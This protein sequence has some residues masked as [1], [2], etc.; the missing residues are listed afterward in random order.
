MRGSG[1]RIGVDVGATLA[2]VARQDGGGA[3]VFSWFPTDAIEQLAREVESLR[4]EKIALTGGGAAALEGHLRGF[5]TARVGEFEAWAAGAAQLLEDRPGGAPDRYLLVSLGT[6]TSAMLVDGETVTRAGGTALGGGTLS[7]LAAA[8]VG[9]TRFEAIAELARQGDR[10]R[11]DLQVAE[12]YPGRDAPLPGDL[13]ASSFAKLA[14]NGDEPS[15]ADLVR[16]VVGL[17]GE[18]VALVCGWM[19]AALGVDLIVYGGST[20]RGNAALEE[21]LVG[22][23]A[24]LGRE[25]VILPN[26]EYTG[27]IGALEAA[28]A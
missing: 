12:V 13:N 1:T 8:L 23:G 17:V 14:R 16:G 2:K 25:V 27:A 21:I 4:P 20:L 11:V 6:G 28:G 19:A 18:N 5:D 10:R 22:V 24:M 15:Q 9:E 7:G 26:G 3:F